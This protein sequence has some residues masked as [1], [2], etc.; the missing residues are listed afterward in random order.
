VPATANRELLALPR[1]PGRPAID[2]FR[3]RQDLNLTLL[4]TDYPKTEPFTKLV[5]L[6]AFYRSIGSQESRP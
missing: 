3:E 5:C 1:P 2:A 6:L 4:R